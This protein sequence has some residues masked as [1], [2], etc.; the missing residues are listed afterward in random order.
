MKIFRRKPNIEKLAKNEDIEGLF[1]ALKYRKDQSIRDQAADTLVPFL[2]TE[3]GSLCVELLFIKAL[4]NPDEGVRES[5]AKCYAGSDRGAWS[6]VL[7][8]G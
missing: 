4:L 3:L 1:E 7:L 6:T 5:H 8:I 2:C